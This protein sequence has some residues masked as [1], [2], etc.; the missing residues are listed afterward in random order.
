MS[1][2]FGSFLVARGVLSEPV[3]PTSEACHGAA[4]LCWDGWGGEV[5]LASESE[6][7]EKLVGR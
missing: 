2:F 3:V 7:G 5:G 4:V 1:L 6:V